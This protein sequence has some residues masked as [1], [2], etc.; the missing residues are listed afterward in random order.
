MGIT[1]AAVFSAALVFGPGQARPDAAAAKP[2]A[3]EAAWSCSEWYEEC[4]TCGEPGYWVCVW[5]RECNGRTVCDPNP[6]E[7]GSAEKSSSLFA[8]ATASRPL[9]CKS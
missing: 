8:P 1:L 4:Y 6:C 3:L 7:G 5:C 2:V 9:S